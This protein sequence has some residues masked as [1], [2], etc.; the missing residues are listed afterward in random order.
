MSENFM[1]EKSDLREDVVKHIKGW[2]VPFVLLF[3]V[4]ASLAYTTIFSLFRPLSWAILLAFIFYPAYRTLLRVTGEAHKNVAA[5]AITS[6]MIMLLVVPTLA[7]GVVTSRETIGLFER[8]TN[9]LGGIDASKG[10]SLEMLLPD[11]MVTELLPM[12]DRYPSLKDGTQQLLSW[13]TSTML[14][15]SRNFLGN[16]VTL[17]YHQIIIFIAFYFLLRDG[18]LLL[19]YFKDIIPLISA[20]RDEFMHRADVVLRAVVFGVVVTAGVQG[21]LG[22]LGWWFVGLSSPLLAGAMMALLAMIPFVGTPTVWI[23][24]AIYL[25]LVGNVKNCVMLI[26]WGLCVVSTVDNFLRPY[27]ISEKAKMSTLLIFFGA[28]GGL[29]AW[30]FIGLFVG[31]LILS[32]FVFSLDSYRK[33]WILYQ[34]THPSGEAAASEESP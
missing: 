10:L 30:G 2:I 32:L 13:G 17:L 12:F 29:A 25:F 21:I 3:L 22:A 11:V 9:L 6:L 27:F 28:F 19:Q 8:I 20:E 14:R 34:A 18:H 1:S 26:L 5:L 33:I 31:P 23:P 4:L 16:I 15:L 7:A 24:G